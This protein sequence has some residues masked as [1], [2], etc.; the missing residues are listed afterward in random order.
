[1]DQ[2]SWYISNLDAP[3]SLYQVSIFLH[4]LMVAHPPIPAIFF[5]CTQFASH[6]NIMIDTLKIDS[7]VHRLLIY[8]LSVLHIFN[9]D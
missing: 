6:H 3:F 1:M 8:G 5:N 7:K 2:V 9:L 4:H